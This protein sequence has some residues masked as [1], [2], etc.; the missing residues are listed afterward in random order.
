MAFLGAGVSGQVAEAAKSGFIVGQ[1]HDSRRVLSIN[2]VSV[3]AN[4]AAVLSMPHSYP[5][6]AECNASHQ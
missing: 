1:Q 4:K 3:S 2:G 6:F 5:T